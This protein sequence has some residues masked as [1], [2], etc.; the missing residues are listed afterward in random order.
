MDITGHTNPDQIPPD[1]FVTWIFPKLFRSRLPRYE[2]V[3]NE[4]G[5]IVN[6]EDIAD[7]H[8]EQDFVE[9]ITQAIAKQRKHKCH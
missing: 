4:Y 1:D 5:Y 3:A 7:V 8:N 9:L 2:A 6:A